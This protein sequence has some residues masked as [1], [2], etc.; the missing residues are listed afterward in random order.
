MFHRLGLMLNKEARRGVAP[1]KTPLPP[2]LRKERGIQGVRLINKNQRGFT[3]IELLVAIAIT[4]LITG[5]LT[6]TIF[7]VF[8][9]NAR[10]NDHMT[11][12]REVQNAGYWIS[13]DTQMAQ[14]MEITGVSGF[15]LTLTWNE[16]GG[17]DVHEVVYTLL[18]DNKLQREHYTNRDTNPVPDAATIIAQYIDPDN[19][20]CQFTGIIGSDFSLPDAPGGSEDAFTIT[21]AVGGDSGT[22]SVAGPGSVVKVTPT[23]GATVDG[24]TNTVTLGPGG[25]TVAWAT[26]VAGS[27]IIV[28]ANAT[29]S[30]GSWTSTTGTATATITTD[31]DSDAYLTDGGVLILTVTA[32]VGA[33][34]QEA[35]ETR[36]YEVTPRP[37]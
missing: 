24:G 29:T 10:S 27:T 7:Q 28:T 36:I 3:L 32:T 15:P 4:G 34:S 35:S 11:A 26:P 6:T 30:S 37:D 5:G 1:S 13:R 31:N 14:S 2:R 21:D 19:T 23:G 20:N 16:Y 17:G 18:V 9:I 22:I 12:V 33:G 25:G 8:D